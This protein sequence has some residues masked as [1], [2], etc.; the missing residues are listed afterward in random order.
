MRGLEK[1]L[2]T[3]EGEGKFGTLT[4]SRVFHCVHQDLRSFEKEMAGELWDQDSE[5]LMQ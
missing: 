1:W 2:R 5:N 4:R 3:G